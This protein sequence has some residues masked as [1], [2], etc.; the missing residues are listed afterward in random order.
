[1]MMMMNPPD[2]TPYTPPPFLVLHLLLI[3]LHR[4]PVD[5]E[6]SGGI[7]DPI[8]R[9]NC[10]CDLF[11]VSPPSRFL[12]DMAETKIHHRQ[13]IKLYKWTLG[14]YAAD[15]IV[16]LSFAMMKSILT[17]TSASCSFYIYIYT[18]HLPSPSLSLTIT[19]YH[20]YHHSHVDEI[21]QKQ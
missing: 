9:L 3:S 14:E 2:L 10:L 20:Q 21:P 5:T 7:F 13:L 15:I 17:S 8:P 18:P 6:D 12:L 19:L 4:D 11:D 16:A 1:M